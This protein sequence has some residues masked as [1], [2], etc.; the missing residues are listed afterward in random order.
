MG[1]GLD[2]T[3][4]RRF[5]GLAIFRRFRRNDVEKYFNQ[6]FFCDPAPSTG[7]CRHFIH[8]RWLTH[9]WNN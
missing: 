6:R 2:E 8:P 1:P 9:T 7:G 5:G 3:G 4:L